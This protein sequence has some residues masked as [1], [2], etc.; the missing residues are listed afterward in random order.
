MA[1]RDN[2]LFM[3]TFAQ[4]AAAGTVVPLSLL[5]GVENVRTGYG[6]A[7]L[8]NVRAMFYGGYAE[9]IGIPIEIKNSNWIDP[10]GLTAQNATSVTLLNRD[11]LGF[12]RG[13]GKELA[14]NTAWTINAILPASA[15]NAGTVYVLFEIEYSD[16][17]GFDSE[18]QPGSSV[19]KKCENASVTA[20]ANVPV[21]LGSFDNLLTGTEYLLAEVSSGIAGANQTP[22][23][24]I[25][26][27]F[28]NQ[29][30]LIRIIPAMSVGLADQIEG[31]VKLTKQTYS[32]G[33]IAMANISARP[34][35]VRFEMVASKN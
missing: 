13:R 32:V 11:S 15:T 3:G 31:S 33:L 18:K 25:I 24:I 26:E 10:A 16:V 21:S 4:G 30:G 7:K 12:L 20:S 34:V 9:T 22:H 29:R 19:L 28:S 5:Y 17:P 2:V 8:Q 27:G 1:A 35:S 14:P 23:F 6:S